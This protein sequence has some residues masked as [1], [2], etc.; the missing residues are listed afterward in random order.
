MLSTNPTEQHRQVQSLAPLGYRHPHLNS[1]GLVELILD[2]RGVVETAESLMLQ[3][4]Y[5]TSRK[6]NQETGCQTVFQFAS[7]AVEVIQ[8]L[9]NRGHLHG[10]Q[11]ELAGKILHT[12]SVKVDGKT[13]HVLDID[14]DPIYGDEEEVKVPR[15][16]YS[17]H[18]HPLEAYQR[19]RVTVAWPSMSDYMGYL[20]FGTN[21]IFHCV[22]AKEGLYIISF[23]E[24][25][26]DKL[27]YV[28]R[29]FVKRM[30][31]ISQRLDLTPEEYVSYVNSIVHPR[32][33]IEEDEGLHPVFHVQFI[34]WQDVTKP[35]TIQYLREHDNCFLSDSAR[36]RRRAQQP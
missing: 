28:N 12:H 23:G 15:S 30:Y 5:L 17:Y 11:R 22:C 26:V 16:R 19:N 18:S 8:D 13:V 33:P 4:A 9:P 35:F 29:D 21:T 6:T 31:K 36:Q 2:P 32:P 7:D 27:R 3:I 10:T 20:Y 25:W 24:Y 14:G 34:R 1:R